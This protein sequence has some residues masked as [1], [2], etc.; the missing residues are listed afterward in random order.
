MQPSTELAHYVHS[1][2]LH[3]ITLNITQLHTTSG[4]A[5][6]QLCKHMYL[7]VTPTKTVAD[8]CYVQRCQLIGANSRSS[9]PNSPL[10]AA[11]HSSS[12]VCSSAYTTTVAL[13]S[14]TA[15]LVAAA[16]T[17]SRST[18]AAAASAAAAS[19]AAA[20]AAAAATCVAAATCN[21]RSQLC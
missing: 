2:H 9:V 12:L 6:L 17:A 10:I 18:A 20:A 14:A 3:V 16:V 15:A 21:H 5:L 19:A 11:T 1:A 7:N 8:Y 4:L 13:H